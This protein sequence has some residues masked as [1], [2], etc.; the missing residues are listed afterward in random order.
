MEEQEL[1][2]LVEK[3]RYVNKLDSHIER[4]KNAKK[5]IEEKLKK[6]EDPRW[7]SFWE[8]G[9]DILVPYPLAEI[10]Y[11]IVIDYYLDLQSEVREELNSL[12]IVKR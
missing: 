2:K 10:V 5:D 6:E 4:L 11:G 12:E 9:A 1:V 8:N 7:D 3:V